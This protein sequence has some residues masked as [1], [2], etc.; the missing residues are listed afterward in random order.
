[1][2]RKLLLAA[3]GLLSVAGL[4]AQPALKWVTSQDGMGLEIPQSI[5]ASA[6]GNV[7]LM[8]NFAS[9]GKETSH[10]P[11]GSVNKG[12]STT[13][14]YFYYNMADGT[15]T[16]EK[17]CTGVPD[18]VM[19]NGNNNLTLYKVSTD[20]HLLWAVHTNVGEFSDGAMAPTSDGGVTVLLKMRHSS[21]AQYKS[22]IICQL[23]DAEG[24]ETP[25]KWDAPDYVTYG[26]V[27]QP[28]L[29]KISKDGKVVRT[30]RIEVGYKV[31][32]INGNQ[33][34]LSDNFDLR[35]MVADEEDNLYLVGTY[36][37]SI[38]FGRNANLSSPRSAE[39]WDGDIQK[40]CGDLFVVKLNKED[41]A[42]WNVVTKGQVIS[43]EIPKNITLDNGNLYVSG[44]MK[45]DGEATVML[46]ND[47]LTPSVKDCLFYT[48]IAPADGSVKWAHLLQT[49]EHPVT[50]DGAR[51]KPMCLTA[52][53]NDLYI[54]GSFYGN[55]MDGEK[56][57]LENPNQQT[58]GL[59][60]FILKC[61]AADGAVQTGVKIEGSLTEVENLIAK[62]GNLLAPGYDLYG[63]SYLYTLDSN[64]SATSLNTYTLK[65]SVSAATQGGIV[66]GNMLVSAMNANRTA[67]FPGCDWTLNVINNGDNNYRACVFTGHDISS[68]STGMASAPAAD[69]NFRVYGG[70]GQLTV[71]TAVSCPV[72]VYG[73]DGRMVLSFEA[74]EGR[75]AQSLPSGLYVVNGHK[76]AIY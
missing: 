29:V 52:S 58:N 11:D 24:T 63:G 32:T 8:N 75:T 62:D 50:K 66:V 45:G 12:Y 56:T 76:V 53:G 2:N 74:S 51:M 44:Y 72:R 59:R 39:G 7:F 48:C 54:G 5:K 33:K 42:Q 34:K 57:W 67:T 9:S 61:N 55:I 23:V 20:G 4:S 28:I 14:D 49:A 35:D 1:M 22:D 15:K 25:V 16:S 40:T 19:T 68:L 47:R 73:I 46:G 31:V 69:D 17:T 60:A 21:R 64:L 71:E 27:Y 43:C 37:T 18:V 30:K 70:K 38:N 10:E 13:T 65:N 26:G 36:R 41:V 6:D 3:V